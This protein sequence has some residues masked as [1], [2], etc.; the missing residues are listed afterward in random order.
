MVIMIIIA[1]VIGGLLIFLRNEI[2]YPL[3]LTWAFVGIWVKQQV[4]YNLVAITAL[5]LAIL[6]AALAIG[7]A[8][9]FKSKTPEAVNP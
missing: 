3:V 1:A 5:T 8:F 7:R 4:T 9:F 2:G 6:I